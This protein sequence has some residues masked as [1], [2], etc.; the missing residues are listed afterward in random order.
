MTSFCSIADAYGSD[1]GMK[2]KPESSP[3][4]DNIVQAN[5]QRL[6]KYGQA[7]EGQPYNCP[8][9]KNCNASN[10]KFQ[11]QIVDQ[12][13]WPRP[14]WIPQDSG[15]IVGDP[16]SSRY[17]VPPGRGDLPIT[18]N[19]LGQSPTYMGGSRRVEHFGN[20]WDNR[21]EYFGN[22]VSPSNAENLLKMILWLLISLFIIQLVDMVI[23]MVTDN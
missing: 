19:N 1:F 11:Q 12:A 17:Y 18:I 15:E 16:Y 4:N 5:E 8:Y 2:K 21:V 23:K 7:P 14:R 22:S 20:N 6:A 9:C 3:K 13:I 10:N